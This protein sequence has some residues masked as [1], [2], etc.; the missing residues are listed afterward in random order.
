MRSRQDLR[1]RYTCDECGVYFPTPTGLC[2][3]C[4]ALAQAPLLDGATIHH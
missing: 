2:A 4:R 3:D 1:Q